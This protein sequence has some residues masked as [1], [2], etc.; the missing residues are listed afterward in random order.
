MPH[1]GIIQGCPSIYTCKQLYVINFLFFDNLTIVLYPE[2]HYYLLQTIMSS[3]NAP[4]CNRVYG[5]LRLSFISA[6]NSY[7]RIK[8]FKDC[9]ILINMVLQ[10]LK[11]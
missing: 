5:Y 1:C 8:P 10:Q 2:H 7:I 3:N 6:C 9:K 11:S 4:V